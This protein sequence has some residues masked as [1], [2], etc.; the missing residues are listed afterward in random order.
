MA[1]CSLSPTFTILPQ[2]H[3][4]MTHLRKILFHLLL[5]LSA[6]ASAQEMPP[7]TLSQPLSKLYV[8]NISVKGSKKTKDYVIV[9][10]MQFSAGDSLLTSALTAEL[11][12]AR[13]QIYNTALFTEVSVRANVLSAYDITVEVEVKER[14][15]IFPV[16]QF[17]FADRNINEWI[18]TYN[19]D[20][21][22]VNYGLKF[23][24][25]NLSGRRDQLRIFLIN[26]FSRD[27]SFSYTSPG[28]NPSLTEGFTV[29]GGYSRNRQVAYTTSYDNVLQF[30]STSKTDSANN[31]LGD[32]VRS[33]WFFNAGYILRRG[34]LNRHLFTLGYSRF[35][36]TDSVA[37][38]TYNPNYFKNGSTSAGYVE[39]NYSLLHIN[40]DNALYPLKGTRFNL[41]VQKRGLG[42]TGGL[43][44]FSVEGF[45][46]RLWKLNDDWYSDVFMNAKIK[47][48]FDQPYFN[49]RGLGFGESYLRGLEY[50]VIDGSAFGMLRSTLKR[51]VLSFSLPMP[52]KSFRSKRIPFTFF[53][54]SYADA[55]YAYAKKKYDTYLNNRLL[56]TGGIG[57]DMVT[58]YDFVL[59]FEYSFN[60]LGQKGLFLHTQVGF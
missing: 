1:F 16:P 46:N 56:Y 23:I 36:I 33:N 28:S 41:I 19:A 4:L 15:Y 43:N 32:F 48:P 45:Y 42:F 9:R 59:R 53:A 34:I 47:L 54:K 18:K 39:F 2:S 38:A 37:S 25:Y 13:Q 57:I 31:R 44:M 58:F 14:W 11:D 17:K 8:K 27:I 52:F 3:I 10:E 7:G 26:G 24:H 20:L 29:S 35:T 55:G 30:F 50:Q 6:A 49:Q 60:Q 22:R 40:V 5:L 51:K 12:R 21:N